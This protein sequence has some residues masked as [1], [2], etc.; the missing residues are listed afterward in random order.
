VRLVDLGRG[1]KAGPQR[2]AAEGETSGASRPTISLRRN[3]GKAEE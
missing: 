3:P 2:M 1:G